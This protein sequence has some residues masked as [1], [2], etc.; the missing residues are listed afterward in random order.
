MN[1]SICP[2]PRF[3][4]TYPGTGNPL[5]GGQ[6]Y[7]LQPGTV[8]VG[9]L[10]A[11]YTDSTGSTANTNPVI[12]DANGEADVWLSG[13]TKLVLLDPTG[14]QVWSEDNVSSMPNTSPTG[15]TEWIT[16][17]G[18]VLTYLS[19][20]QFSTP[21]DQT[22]LFAPEQ[23]VKAT[24]AAGIIYGTVV[25]SSTGGS[26]VVTTVT[27]LWDTGIL[28]AGLSAIATGIITASAHS[29]LPGASVNFLTGEI[30]MYGGASAPTGWLLC[31]GSAVSRTTY[32]PLFAVIG[33]TY[34]IGDN[35][36]TF[37][38]PD[39]RGKVPV[40]AGQATPPIWVENTTYNLNSVVRPTAS[41]NY[42]YEAVS[43]AP[44]SFTWTGAVSYGTFSTSGTGISSAINTSGGTESASTASITG[45][46][47]GHTY[48]LAA[49]LTLNSGQAP[50]LSATGATLSQQLQSGAQ[51]ILF[52]ATGTAVTFT[53]TNT[54]N[55]NFALSAVSLVDMNQAG[56]SNATTEPTWPTT[57]GSTVADGT[58]TWACR[59]K[60]SN[61]T[62]G[63]YGGAEAH[64]QTVAEL[65]SHNHALTDPGHSHSMVQPAFGGGF[66]VTFSNST[67]A[68]SSSTGTS[69]TGIT[70][71]LTGG[72][73]PM[74][75]MNP[76]FTGNWIIKT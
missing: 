30:K 14:V 33:T 35:S 52:T 25:T 72:G 63:A 56:T 54:A 44:I 71:G 12:L 48:N 64:T 43:S 20:T 62:L 36:T 70:E 75:V 26:P 42:V 34:G 50:T 76:F 69:T 4:A 28:D 18:L 41:Y 29:S 27:V 8:G 32:A 37:N 61:R 11:T 5:A 59:A 49:T 47:I 24:V 74:N 67:G 2:Y 60:W 46:T 17:S 9:S 57:I 55:A 58:I 38:L 7:T 19:T 45:L 21:G 31:D 68:G 16:Q 40:G 13:Y 53:L 51:L 1:V 73:N 3:K 22:T 65:V 10:K 6:L 66:N 39:G 23:R 15:V